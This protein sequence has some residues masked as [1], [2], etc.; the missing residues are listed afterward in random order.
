MPTKKKSAKEEAAKKKATADEASDE[1]SDD[2]ENGEEAKAAEDEAPSTNGQP[3]DEE[4]TDEKA[5]GEDAQDDDSEGEDKQR[6]SEDAPAPEDV[7]AASE[8]PDEPVRLELEFETYP[9]GAFDHDDLGLDEDEVLEMYRSMLLQRRFE[10]RCRQQYQ[11]QNISGFLHLYIGQEAVSTG[12]VAAIR[13]GEDSV[14]TAYR[15]HGMGLA[16]GLDPGACMAE[17]FGKKTGVTK[18]KGG[19][20][21]FFDR[22]V[23][24]FGGHGIV[25]AHVPLGA[26]IAFA[27]KYREEDNVCLCFFGDGAAQQGAFH[28]ALNLAG[29]YDLPVVFICEN[30]QYGMGTHIDRAAANPD[31]YQQAA[32]YDMPGGVANGMDAFSVNR[33]VQDHVELA[34]DGRPSLLEM[35]TYRYQGHSISDPANYRAEGELGAQ[36]EGDPI[37]RLK[38]YLLDEGLADDDALDE[39]DE[40]AKQTVLDAIEFAEESDLPVEDA[41]YENVYAGEYPFLA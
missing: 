41:L 10:E 31:L 18:G 26:G 3:S 40:D 38:K 13:H 12:S 19:S 37:I 17:L 33:A 21:H 30:N 9:A 1:A 6:A 16:M 7:E 29:L 25:G 15:D 27:H 36:Q 34:R 2:E 5:A 14:I 39:L 4:A 22:E 8:V 11:N 23:R 24:F 32:G 28:E 20:M 35:R